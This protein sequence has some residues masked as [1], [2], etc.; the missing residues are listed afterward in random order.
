MT[1]STDAE[2]ESI[3]TDLARPAFAGDDGVHRRVDP[4]HPLDIYAGI[5]GD[6]QATFLLISPA[7]PPAFR[8][9]RSVAIE[10]RK[11]TD[12]R[13]SLLL[14]L[15]EAALRPIFAR[16][17]SDLVNATRTGVPPE[18]GPAAVL[19]RLDR[20][21]RLLDGQ[22][23]GLGRSVLMGMV[24][25]L[26]VLRDRLIPEIGPDGA[27]KAWI[28]PDGGNQDFRLPNGLRIEIKAAWADQDAVNINGLDQ[29]DG[30]ADP[31]ELLIVRLAETAA[32][33][34]DALSAPALIT[35]L[36]ET[37]AMHP[38][39]LVEFESLLAA[40]HWHDHPSHH[41]F[42]VRFLGA[43]RHIVDDRFPRLVRGNVPD[44]V[45]D[46]HYVLRL[47]PTDRL[48]NGIG[49]MTGSVPDGGVA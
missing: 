2:I 34:S 40:L 42:V 49:T 26:L 48:A 10:A 7:R 11:R 36:R 46:A 21:S 3:W 30:Q 16:L 14:A 12:G 31:I 35:G 1:T 45:A 18:R 24:A 28:G 23:T 47:P 8:P 32:S 33:A 43:E 5:R 19:T 22:P 17:C 44:A 41:E 37:L 27:V 29:L 4:E 6:A 25:E 39:A 9:L 13:F 38:A 15:E 20:W